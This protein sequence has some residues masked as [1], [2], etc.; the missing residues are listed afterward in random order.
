MTTLEKGTVIK[1]G[2]FIVSIGS[3]N[4]TEIAIISKSTGDFVKF[5][6]IKKGG[7]L[8]KVKRKFKENLNSETTFTFSFMWPD[9]IAELIKFLKK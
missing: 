5:K 3:F 9:T 4:I 8:A 7:K 2:N 6:D 1:A